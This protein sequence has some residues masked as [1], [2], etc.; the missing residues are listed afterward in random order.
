MNELL[1]NL[2]VIILLI[3]VIILAV[4]AVSGGLSNTILL[5][6]LGL[7]I[8]GYLSHIVINKRLG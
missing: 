2:G 4:P 7:I 3:G 1:K 6:G 8:L 5:T